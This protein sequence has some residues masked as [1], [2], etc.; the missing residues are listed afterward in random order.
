[1]SLT[2]M[3]A[4]AVPLALAWG[5]L[6]LLRPVDAPSAASAPRGSGVV[7]GAAG[8][9]LPG[10]H[11]LATVPIRA[12][13]GPAAPGRGAVRP[14]APPAP[15]GR[16]NRGEGDWPDETAIEPPA[17]WPEHAGLP[18]DPESATLSAHD[19]GPV[20]LGEPLDPQ[21]PQAA[22]ADRREGL[23]TDRLPVHL[24]WPQDPESPDLGP[25]DNGAAEHVGQPQ[26]PDGSSQGSQ[27]DRDL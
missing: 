21:D 25:L 24:G 20:L 19:S 9:E 18:M 2:R 5:G 17:T 11:P 14:A 3:A 23:D 27:S 16:P 13:A 4:L 7:A 22:L 6:T 26:D 10:A 8:T 15:A 1:M 12:S